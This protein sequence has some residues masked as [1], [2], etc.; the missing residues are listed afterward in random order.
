MSSPQQVIKSLRLHNERVLKGEVVSIPHTAVSAADLIE[1]LLKT[2]EKVK[3][4]NRAGQRSDE[5]RSKPEN[6]QWETSYTK[7]VFEA[8]GAIQIFHLLP[9]EQDAVIDARNL[10]LD[11]HDTQHAVYDQRDTARRD[12]LRLTKI[13]DFW[14]GIVHSLNDK[15]TAVKK[16]IE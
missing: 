1:N 6:R 10:L 4:K 12:V 14:I 2:V 11:Y 8:L 15:L 13:R 16:A 7:R 5:F 3:T 9:S